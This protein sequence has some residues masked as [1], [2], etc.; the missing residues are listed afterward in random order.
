[1]FCVCDVL[2]AQDKLPL[3]A[4]PAFRLDDDE[5]FA[6]THKECQPGE[7]VRDLFADRIIRRTQHPPKH[8][9]EFAE[10]LA[11]FKARVR[12]VQNSPTTAYAFTD[13]SVL[14]G[15]ASKSAA[16]FRAYRGRTQFA[17]R[18]ISCGKATPYDAEMFA[19]AAAVGALTGE[20]AGRAE[21]LH[22][23]TDCLSAIQSITDTAIHPGQ[24][25]SI[26]ACQRLRNWLTAHPH[27][28]VA[29]H[30]C[31]GHANIDLN[32][33]VDRDAKRAA[34]TLPSAPHISLAFRQQGLRH[35]ALAEWRELAARPE[36]RGKRFLYGRRPPTPPDRLVRSSLLSHTG[37]S[38]SLTAR[39][40]RA[41]LN[42][43]PTGE[44]RRRFFPREKSACAVC[45]V[46]QSRRH[47]I[48][49]CARY[50]RR[51]NFYEFLK[52]SS[53]P[54]PHLR[55]FLTKN[56]TALSFDDAP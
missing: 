2:R 12:D 4:I 8:G 49:S 16:A 34:A 31:P 32:E 3:H 26:L 42:H 47:I 36:H 23:F 7:R 52:N 53:E 11:A 37:N 30:W 54:G 33:L 55:D 28:T 46:L 35:A 43:A 18:T 6:P 22:L 44:Y 9:D 29:F 39:M 19:L 15:A 13:G 51:Q 50:Q 40:A 24:S 56:P 17:A 45:G 1:V 48:S 38:T 27:G 20:E 5:P 21:H 10:W 25:I 41:V 14:P